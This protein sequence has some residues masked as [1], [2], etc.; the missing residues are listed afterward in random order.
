MR[1]FLILVS[2]AALMVGVAAC[3]GD[4]DDSASSG[5]TTTTRSTLQRGGRLFEGRDERERLHAG[6]GRHA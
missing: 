5:D 4:D 1:K 6:Q 3:G 2:V